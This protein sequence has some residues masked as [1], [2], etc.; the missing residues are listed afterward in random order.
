MISEMVRRIFQFCHFHFTQQHKSTILDGFVY[1]VLVLLFI[2]MEGRLFIFLPMYAF[3]NGVALQPKTAA[4]WDVNSRNECI[5]FARLAKMKT[6]VFPSTTSARF[7]FLFS[8][9]SFLDIWNRTRFR[10][11]L[12][13]NKIQ[14]KSVIFTDKNSTLFDYFPK[15][16]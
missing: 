9:I 10:V 8:M 16:H 11:Y 2:Q 4:Q 15:F 12:V 3:C 5:N 6:K 13:R 7:F 1:L 14:E